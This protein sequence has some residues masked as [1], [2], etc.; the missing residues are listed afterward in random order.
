MLKKTNQAGLIMFTLIL[1][2]SIFVLSGCPSKG[3]NLKGALITAGSWWQ[4][5][6]TATTEPRAENEEKELEWRLKVEKDYGFKHVVE[7]VGDWDNYLPLVVNNIMSGNKKFSYYQVASEMAIVL[8]KQGLLYPVSD[9]KAVDFKNREIIPFEKN[10][11]N[12]IVDDYMT[13]GGKTYGWGY[14]LPNNGW[15][16]SMLYFNPKF[17]AD[18]G[19]GVEYLYDL[20]RDN[21]WT[22][23]AFLDVCRKLTRDTNNDGITDIYA[24]H[25][26]D[27]REFLGG[28]LIIGNGGDFVTLD[29]NGKAQS[30]VNSPNVIEAINFFNQLINEG[31]VQTSEYYDW[32]SNWTAFVDQRIAMTFDPEWRK[33]QM[34]DGFEAGYVLPPRGPRSATIRLGVMDGCNVIPSFFSPEE[35]DIILKGTEIWCAPPEADWMQGHYWASRNIRDVTETVAMS[36]DV[37]YLVPRYDLIIPGYPYGDFIAAIRADGSGNVAASQ[38]IESFTPRFQAA[39]DDFNR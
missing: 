7:I 2:A 36:R 32:G 1:A 31:L 5:Y 8:Y 23:D 27:A 13:F 35:V 25:I 30:A 19:I 3:V 22:W 37:K 28:G 38:A 34:N 17:L 10:M 15:G 39:I 21:K 18:A 11:Y 12:G 4:D 33:G 6:D 24:I 14:G 29:A 16:Q 26:D 20:Q 9:S